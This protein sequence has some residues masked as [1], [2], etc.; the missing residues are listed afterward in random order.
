MPTQ[1]ENKKRKDNAQTNR[2][3]FSLVKNKDI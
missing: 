3:V 2:S 1:K